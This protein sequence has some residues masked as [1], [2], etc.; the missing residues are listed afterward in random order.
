MQRSR[1]AGLVEIVSNQ[2]IDSIE[3]RVKSQGGD[4]K[5]GGE[6][7]RP[8][9]ALALAATGWSQDRIGGHA[10][11][12]N[13]GGGIDMAAYPRRSGQQSTLSRRGKRNSRRVEM[14]RAAAA[15]GEEQIVE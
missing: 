8:D 2:N 6:R 9:P 4:R 14:R 12:K 11:G 13:A 15:G 10:H 5:I 1:R 3:S 7:A